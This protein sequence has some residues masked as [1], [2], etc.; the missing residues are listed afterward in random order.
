MN[1][2]ITR[3]QLASG[4]PKN[5]KSRDVDE[6]VRE[7]MDAIA[8]LAMVALVIAYATYAFVL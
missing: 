4:V 5:G 8:G 6:I 1:A 7:R 3:K 2:T